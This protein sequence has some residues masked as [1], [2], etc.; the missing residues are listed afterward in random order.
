MRASLLS[1]LYI[2]LS[3]LLLLAL[4]IND[5]NAFSFQR[6]LGPPVR[7][8][9]GEATNLH[10]YDNVNNQQVLPEPSARCVVPQ[11]IPLD[12]LY[13]D[14]DV[15]VINKPSG[16]VM[17]YVPGSVESAVVNYLN[18]TGDNIL[19][20]SPSWPWKS[21]DS[22]EGIVHRTDKETSGI[23]VLAK[24]P[25][26]A[27]AIHASFQ[28]RRV[29]KT[30]LAIAVGLPT[31][32]MALEQTAMHIQVEA[33]AV[34]SAAELLLLQEAAAL[35]G[36]AGDDELVVKPH[37]KRLA[38]DIKNCGRNAGKAL[39][40]INAASDPNAA[41]FSAVISVC[42]RADQRDKALLLFDSMKERGVTPNIPCFKKTISLCAKDNPPMYEKALEL[43]AYMKECNLPLDPHCVSSAISACG[44]AEQLEPALDLLARLL[45]ETSSDAAG[46]VGCFKAAIGAC[47]KCGA[48]DSEVALKEQL[49]IV[50]G[51]V[52]PHEK[53][54]SNASVVQSLSED[55]NIDAPIGKAGRLMAILP[56]SQGGRESRSIVSPLSF[57]GTLSLN[58][59]VI[60]T[61][62][63]H[64][65]RVH[66]ASILDCPLVGDR[67]YNR[68]DPIK[69]AER[70]MLH[71][72]E[73]TFPHPVTGA[74]LKII[75]P[76]PPDF[77]ALA[78]TIRDS[79]SV[80]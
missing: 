39:E 23:L 65:I 16:M 76:P 63:T 22:F 8:R 71:A 14:T 37:L 46:V 19:Y 45:N 74:M 79:S 43:V 36:A 17:Q 57:D 69:R 11:N 52:E 3:T 29:N 18:M 66:M 78:D 26:A 42:K 47:K 31:R 38:K 58:S 80:Q 12:I 53:I 20:N 62:R 15:L 7:R 32:E 50:T 67:L 41:C 40:L 54:Y 44:R 10:V 49:K 6:T 70:C 60:L 61:G 2:V 13:E 64:Q 51:K 55:I 25:L 48:T 21:Q 33:A 72:T 4:R 28:E 5:C 73:L 56:N 1:S 75:C 59:V 30:Y 34:A 9:R 27:S 77:A 35:T 68:D 24:N